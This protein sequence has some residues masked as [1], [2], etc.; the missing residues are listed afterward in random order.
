MK[1]LKRLS[2]LFIAAA[3]LLSL[4]ACSEKTPTPSDTQSNVPESTG[5]TIATRASETA[6]PA[7]EDLS[8]RY[9]GH[10]N[11]RSATMMT[12]VDPLKKTGLWAYQFQTCVFENALTR[13]TNNNIQPAVCDYEL[14][15]DTLT[16]KLWV[17][18][19]IKFSNGD[20]VDI[21]DVEASIT[22]SFTMF[23]SM[24]TKVYPYLESMEVGAD[25]KTLTLKFTEYQENTLYYLAAYQ[26]WCPIMPKEICEKYPDTEI[27]DIADLIGTGPYMYSEWNNPESVTLVRVPGYEPRE[28]DRDRTGF[29]GMKYAFLDSI[30][31]IGNQNDGSAALAVLNG[32]YDVVECIP[33]EYY[34]LA[35]ASGLKET[36][37]PSNVGCMTYFNVDNSKDESGNYVNVCAKYPSLRKAIMAAIDYEAYLTVVTDNQQVM[38]GSPWQSPL[39]QNDLWTSADYYG[40]T[41]LDVAAKY[42]AQAKAEG[43][44]GEEP[45]QIVYSNK[46]TDI[47]TLFQDYMAKAGIPSVVTLMEDSAYSEYTAAGSGNNYDILFVWPTY[48]F[49]PTLQPSYFTARWS[50]NETKNALLE[51]MKTLPTDSAEYIRL[52]REYDELLIDECGA[53][54]M[55]MINWYWYSPQELEFNDQGLVR[56]FFNSY[57]DDPENHPM[58]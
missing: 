1:H 52:A 44:N 27:E 47:P 31:F 37:L 55:S 24:K 4:A 22:R 17:R 41:K 30:T 3:M 45:V 26:T 38:G 19:G 14:S 9:G 2:A 8:A 54:Y 10:A 15:D 23:G 18:D 42:V 36:I 28:A 20:T 46:R 57:W 21:Y 34:Q 50:E 5:N 32:D 29:A 48:S 56:Y 51:Q 11:I 40:P 53:A 35:L 6:P 49:T 16:L 58:K 43:W 25:G 12:K 13:D 7:T 33:S 39:Y